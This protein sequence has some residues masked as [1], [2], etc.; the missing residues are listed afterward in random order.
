MKKKKEENKCLAKEFVWSKGNNEKYKYIILK[1]QVN[2]AM[3]Y[4]R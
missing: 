1:F 3:F 4:V 2:L